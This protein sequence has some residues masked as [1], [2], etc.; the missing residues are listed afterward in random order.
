MG[1]LLSY[2]G[3]DIE[4]QSRQF[5]LDQSRQEVGREE[6]SRAAM[7]T[8]STE[9]AALDP[10]DPEYAKRRMEI[11]NRYPEALY[12]RAAGQFLGLSGDVAS[13]PTRKRERTFEIDATEKRTLDAEARRQRQEDDQFARQLAMKVGR[14]D[15]Y[16]KWRTSYDAA[17]TDE[18]RRKVNDDLGWEHKEWD[19]TTQLI[20]A[21]VPDP[22]K[23][24]EDVPGQPGKK[25][26]GQKARQVL[27][28]AANRLTPSQSASMALRLEEAIAKANM[29]GN[30]D[31]E[32]DLRR[33]LSRLSLGGIFGGTSGT[34][35]A[36]G[37]GLLPASAAPPAQSKG[38]SKFG[39]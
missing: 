6:S 18:D 26:Y 38:G 33:Q 17:K 16:D 19:M 3:K 23:Y 36:A 4:N 2:E 24:R 34:G 1:D 21:G 20:D 32:A 35:V 27:A 30:S 5:A 15:F 28:A 9:I 31:L 7:Q 13:E 25:F 14:R 12:S 37:A 29:A 10:E 39:N 22:E 8:A 11:L